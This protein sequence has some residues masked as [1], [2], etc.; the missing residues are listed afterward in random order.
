M[1]DYVVWIVG[2]GDSVPE[3]ILAWYA[4]SHIALL[5]N[6]AVDATL[7][8]YANSIKTATNHIS[9]DANQ[10]TM[11]VQ[12]VKDA[13][14]LLNAG[15]FLELW[16]IDIQANYEAYKPYVSAIT[17]NKLSEKIIKELPV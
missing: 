13:N 5:S 4:N 9:I 2:S 7:I 14:A 3:T 12:D 17:S 16:T 8:A 15:V 10:N 6:T 1:E 11:S